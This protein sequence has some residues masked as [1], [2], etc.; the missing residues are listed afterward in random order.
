MMAS[1][2]RSRRRFCGFCATSVAAMSAALPRAL[3]AGER[4]LLKRY[5]PVRLVRPQGE[6]LRIDRL[7]PG[8]NYLFQY[9]FASTPCFLIDLGRPV[10]EP[11]ELETREHQPYVWRGGVGPNRSIVAFSA[12]CS[13]RMTHPAPEVSFISYH[14]AGHH[15]PRQRGVIHC[16]SENS[17]Y[18]PAAG[19][20]VLSGPAPEPLAA[21]ELEYDDGN[22][23]LMAVGASG[24]TLFD[25][26]LHEFRFRLAIDYGEPGYRRHVRERTPVVTLDEYTRRPYEC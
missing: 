6:Q 14:P 10:A 13:H 23:T 17:V 20:R 8:V 15:D 1:F 25:R 4:P 19:A 3:E 18:D 9:P 7:V 16:C 26:F 2:D 22:G 12:I 24:G 5:N 11:V 21:I